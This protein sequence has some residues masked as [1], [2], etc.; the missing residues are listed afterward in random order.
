MVEDAE[1]EHDSVIAEGLEE[2]LL[3]SLQQQASQGQ[4]PPGDVARIAELVKSD[5]MEL[6]AAIQKVQ[7]EA[8]ERQ[9]EVV[10]PDAPEAQPGIALPGAGAEATPG[11]GGQAP[12]SLRD[13]L[14]QVG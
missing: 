10:P 9:A 7:A 4:I 1:H 3:T 13:L 14:G 6:A 12:P 8:Q 11:P 2:A 5:R